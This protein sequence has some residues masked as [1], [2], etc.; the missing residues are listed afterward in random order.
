MPKLPR[1]PDAQRL[2]TLAPDIVS[3]PAGRRLWRV[4]F[5][6][7]DNPT[8]WSD[9]RYVGPLDGRFDHHLP[10][11]AGQAQAQS[12]GVLYAAES[13]ITCLAEVFQRTRVMD[14]SHREPW[15]V[16][17]DLKASLQLLN[18]TGSFPTR[19]GASMA[20]MTGPR[21]VARQ[22]AQAFYD[23][24]PSLH[25]LYY[26]SSMQG[27]APSIA[28]NERAATV[29]VIPRQ[30]V[31]HRALADNAILTLVRNAARELGYAVV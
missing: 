15:L 4:Y 23:A 30:P 31:F 21:T 26:P 2:L 5:R 17:F 14:R 29:G 20:L 11:K 25:G 16:A 9:F 12:R 22:W 18:L 28:L 19:A 10:T 7:G 27:N 1:T 8:A 6:G 13:G 24:Y 3:L